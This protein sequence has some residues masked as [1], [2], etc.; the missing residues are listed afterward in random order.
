[1][2]FLAMQHPNLTMLLGFLILCI[3]VLALVKVCLEIRKKYKK[4]MS[5][6]RKEPVVNQIEKRVKEDF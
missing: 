2:L 3:S 1:M 5:N 4:V 6:T